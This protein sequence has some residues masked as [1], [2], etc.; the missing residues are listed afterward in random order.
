MAVAFTCLAN[1]VFSTG[2]DST[3]LGWWSW[4]QVGTGEHWTMFVERLIKYRMDP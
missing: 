1:H 2:A 4:I 3:G